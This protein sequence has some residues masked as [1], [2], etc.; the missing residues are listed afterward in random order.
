VP[1]LPEFVA[2]FGPLRPLEFAAA[3]FTS[4][5]LEHGDLLVHRCGRAVKLDEQRRRFGERKF[6]IGVTGADLQL[7]EQLDPRHRQTYPDG[8]DRSSAGAVEAREGAGCRR[9]PDGSAHI[10]A[11]QATIARIDLTNYL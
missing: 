9:S 7:I 10:G 1:R 4:D 6:G 2:L 5:R 11:R 3:M 8:G